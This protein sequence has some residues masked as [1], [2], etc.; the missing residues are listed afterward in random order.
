MKSAKVLGRF[1][2]DSGTLLEGP[3]S[4]I[5]S[6]MW[7]TQDDGVT[8]AALAHETQLVRG[9]FNVEL[10]RTDQHELPWHYTVIC[11][12]GKWTIRVEDDGPLFLKDLL[13]SRFA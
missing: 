13:P 6:R 1:I 10:T 3:I 5:P 11:P 9:A 7:I 2:D 8:V 4:F 12:V